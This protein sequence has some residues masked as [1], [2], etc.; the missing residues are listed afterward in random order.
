MRVHWAE[1]IIINTIII[2]RKVNK[3]LENLFNWDNIREME[4]DE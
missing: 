3:K 4:K 1:N 2:I